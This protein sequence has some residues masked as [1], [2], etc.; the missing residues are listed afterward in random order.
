MTSALRKQVA[1]AVTLPDTRAAVE[2][3]HVRASQVTKNTSTILDL[4]SKSE[5]D[6]MDARNDNILCVAKGSTAVGRA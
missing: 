1:L 3:A 5:W 4:I 2:A 6:Q